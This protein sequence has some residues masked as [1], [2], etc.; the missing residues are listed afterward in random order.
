MKLA[1]WYLRRSIYTLK[2]T[3]GDLYDEE[4]F[5]CHTLEDVSRGENIKIPHETAIPTGTYAIILTQS[6]RFGRLMPAIISELS[7]YELKN[8]GISFKGI[9]IH[10]GNKANNTDGCVLAARQR[11]DPDTIY[12]S[13][14]KEITKR[15]REIGLKAQNLPLPGEFDYV[16]LIVTNDI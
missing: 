8:K 15:L 12:G 5:L 3:G 11:I 16:Q 1:T 6:T 10:G 4:N 14:E 2:S 9:R 7:G 13:Y